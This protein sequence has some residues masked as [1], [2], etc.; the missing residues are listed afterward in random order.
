[1]AFWHFLLH[2]KETWSH[3]L[4]GML[5]IW[6]ISFRNSYL[7]WVHLRWLHSAHQLTELLWNQLEKTLSVLARYHNSLMIHSN[8]NHSDK[9]EDISKG[10]HESLT[11]TLTLMKQ[12]EISP[13]IAAKRKKRS[14]A[15][16]RQRVTCL[17]GRGFT[18][19]QQLL[20][21]PC[22]RW[23]RQCNYGST[24]GR[25][26]LWPELLSSAFLL[27]SNILTQR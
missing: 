9:N 16:V 7:F 3:G 23:W 6:L 11:L 17:P 2:L 20:R 18:D 5:F 25:T 19:L 10:T 4:A 24:V 8:C 26:S 13:V 14:M 12:Y 27:S 1:M 21:P 22:G 15:S